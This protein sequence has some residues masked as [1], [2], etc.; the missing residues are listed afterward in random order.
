M[1]LET[2]DDGRDLLAHVLDAAQ[3]RGELFCQTQAHA[4]WGLTI[5]PM[6][7]AAF[8]VVTVGECLLLVTGARAPLRLQRGDV[9]LVPHGAGHVLC[10]ALD[11]PR[12]PLEAW[13][14]EREPNGRLLRTLGRRAEP[15]RLICGAFRF[16]RPEGLPP[17]LSLLPPVIRVRAGSLEHD[18]E[19]TPTLQLL[20][21]ELSGNR[22]GAYAT[23]TRLLDVLFVQLLRAWL[24]AEGQGARGWLGALG[25]PAVARALAC[26]HRA[27]QRAWTLATLAAQCGVSR[28]VLAR[29][30][31][32]TLR[33]SPLAY[34]TTVRM[35]RAAALLRQTDASLAHIAA[36]VGYQSEFAFNRAFRRAT[37]APP[38][39]Y[40]T[41]ARR[42]AGG[43]RPPVPLSRPGV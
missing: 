5:A 25:T 18:S 22:A 2:L 13:R 17:L 9:A 10:D 28:A 29:H 16:A 23:V 11:S 6:P 41:G 20:S 15:T 38:G 4:P 37:G 12:L 42:A 30:F 21:R 26:L 27:P 24:E 39:R 3:L 31:A 36:E 8:H 14:A 7:A 35:E 1:E 32:R 40:R 33:T 19:L 34:L 43:R